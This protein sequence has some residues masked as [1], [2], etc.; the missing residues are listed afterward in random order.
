MSTIR[1]KLSSYANKIYSTVIKRDD[2]EELKR[3]V[4]GATLKPLKEDNFKT[5]DPMIPNIDYSYHNFLAVIVIELCGININSLC[6]S[7]K[8]CGNRHS[9]V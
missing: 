7:N 5:M 6:N 3:T 8:W 9:V 1:E 4:I 2:A